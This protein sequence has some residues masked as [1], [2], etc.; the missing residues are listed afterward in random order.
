MA[1]KKKKISIYLNKKIN[2]IRW[3]GGKMAKRM[4]TII[5]R[6][7]VSEAMLGII[8][9]KGCRPPHWSA[10]IYIWNDITGPPVM[11]RTNSQRACTNSLLC[12]F[13]HKCPKNLSLSLSL[14]FLRAHVYINDIKWKNE[15]REKRKIIKRRSDDTQ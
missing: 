4:L 7:A 6:R 2:I 11:H 12:L 15:K 5:E 13:L 10:L 1:S 3:C 8:F 9:V 14:E